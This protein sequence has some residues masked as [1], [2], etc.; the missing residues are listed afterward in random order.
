MALDGVGVNASTATGS[1]LSQLLGAP[2]V[3]D[4]LVAT[5]GNSCDSWSRE[6]LVG[7]VT[8]GTNPSCKELGNTSGMSSTAGSTESLI[9][10]EDVSNKAP[11]KSAVEPSFS[12]GVKCDLQYERVF[13]PWL[14][15]D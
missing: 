15:D 13:Q 7:A 6:A 11:L 3:V 5:E 12:S 14:T 9:S 10:P 4:I 8:M 1:L 2:G